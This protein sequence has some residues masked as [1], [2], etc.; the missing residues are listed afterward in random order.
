MLKITWLMESHAGDLKTQ[1]I[2][3]MAG[4]TLHLVNSKIN[5]A[6]KKLTSRHE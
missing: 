3:D 2:D 4:Y 1:R 5:R 6:M